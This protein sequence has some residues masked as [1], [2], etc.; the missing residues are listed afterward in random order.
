MLP[1][2]WHSVATPV[3]AYDGGIPILDQLGPIPDSVD[4]E[5]KFLQDFMSV[6]QTY[7]WLLY[8]LLEMSSYL[9]RYSCWRKSVS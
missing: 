4:K 3:N 5:N 8:C 7:C 2:T 6:G 1:E 9:F